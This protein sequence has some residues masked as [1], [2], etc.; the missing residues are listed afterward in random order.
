MAEKEEDIIARA[1]KRFDECMEWEQTTRQ[2]FKDDIRFLFADPDN[3]DQWDAAVKARRQIAGQPMV[4]INKTHTHWLHVVNEAKE[5]RPAIRVVPTGDQATYQSAQIFGGIIRH[6]EERSKA[7]TA[8]K[9]ATE[10]QVGGGIGYWR[11]VTKYVDENSFDQELI[12]KQVPDPLSV[13]LDPY[14]KERNGSDA[15]FGFIYEDMPRD[16]FEHKYPDLDPGPMQANGVAGWVLKDTVRVA[17]YYEVKVKKE[18]LYAIEKEDGSDFM[19]ESAME[20]NERKLFA[21]AFRQGAD[22]IQ[23]RR[24]DKRTVHSYVIAGTKIAE[25]GIWA[26]KYV[27]IIRCPGEEVVLEGRLDRKGLVRYMK[28]AQRAYNYN[29]SASLEF[30]ALQ[31]KTPWVGPIEAFEGFENYWATANT[32]NHAYLPFNNANEDGTPIQPPTRQDPPTAAPAYLQGMQA[33]AQELMMTS[34]QYEA[35]FSEQGNEVSG[36]AL[37]GRKRQGERVTFHFLDAQS[38][39]IAFTGVQLIDA[40]PHYYDTKR[41]IRIMAEDGEEQMIQIDPDA[42]QALQQQ[43]QAQANKI[44]AIFNPN[45]GTYDVVAEVGPS[46][47]SRR[48]EAFNAMKELIAAVPEL[49]QVIGDLFMGTADFPVADKLQERMRNWIPKT[50]LGEGPTPQEQQLQQQLQTAMQTIQTLNE[51]LQEKSTGLQ[52]EAKRIDMDALN[53][54]ALRMENERQDMVNAFKAET[55]RMKALLTAL[56]PEQVT[57]VVRKMVREITDARDPG[58]DL[59]PAKLDPSTTF[60]LGLPDVTSPTPTLQLPG[61]PAPQQAVPQPQ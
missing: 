31:S 61:T 7:Q 42:K 54:L 59:N 34:G 51:R 25:R 58:Q 18:W 21:E 28:D 12:I 49:A 43:E 44:Q 52:L 35:T 17:H 15:R 56:D 57:S 8:Y 19:R 11:I 5:N 3:Q 32:Q 48:Q 24:V 39:A 46:Y 37:D 55:D 36:V 20:P 2:R 13:A 4:T 60:A 30:G 26:G 29:T 41:V 33:A 40:I 27:P 50:I 53:H 47:A 22:G 10:M 38:D 16:T 1:H 9:I 6:I 23:R 45:V 14:I